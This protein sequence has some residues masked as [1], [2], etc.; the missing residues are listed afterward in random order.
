METLDELSESESFGM[1]LVKTF[2]LSLASSAG[3]LGGLIVAGFAL[4]AVKKRQK[5]KKE[6]ISSTEK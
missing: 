5:S 2:T 6:T 4:E 3:I 1:L